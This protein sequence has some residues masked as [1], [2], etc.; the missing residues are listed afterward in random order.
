MRNISQEL[1][2]YL[3]DIDEWDRKVRNGDYG[4]D[5]PFFV[6]CSHYTGSDPN[7]IRPTLHVNALVPHRDEWGR[8]KGEGRH[9]RRLRDGRPTVY[10][11]VL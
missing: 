1:G 4:D 6:N 9:G 11:E 7:T 10:G 3:P 8:V 2:D 5:N